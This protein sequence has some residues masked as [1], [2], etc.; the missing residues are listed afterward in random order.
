LLAGFREA[1]AQGLDIE[2]TFP[3]LVQARSLADAADVAAVLHGRVQR[4]SRAAQ[5]RRRGTGDL[6]AGLIPRARGVGDPEMARALA[7]RDEAMEGRARTLAEQAVE[8][9][10]NWVKR[11]GAP[12]ADP[13][14]RERWMRALS[15]VAAYRDRWHIT[16]EP[17]LGTL[18]DVASTEQRNQRRRAQV[19]AERARAIALGTGHQQVDVGAELPLS[20]ERGVER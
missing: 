7:E 18:A 3:R 2:N 17:V 16:V 19:A 6:V 9:R 10:P 12:P 14:R 15:T 20:V 5:G 11:L 13:V 4:W 8:A 1:E